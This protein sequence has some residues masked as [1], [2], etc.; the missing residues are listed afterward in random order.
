M[1]ELAEEVVERLFA[2]AGPGRGLGRP[3]VLGAGVLEHVEVG[4]DQIGITALVQ[5][6]EHPVAHGLERDPQ[7]CADQRRRS[8]V[9][10]RKG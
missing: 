2:H 10:L 7:E 4:G 6:G 3:D 5:A 9:G 8:G 1:L